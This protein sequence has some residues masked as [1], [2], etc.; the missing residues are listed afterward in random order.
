MK[1]FKQF[2]DNYSSKKL[3]ERVNNLDLGLPLRNLTLNKPR[4]SLETYCIELKKR[5]NSSEAIHKGR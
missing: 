4:R 1:E 3:A 2:M 5:N